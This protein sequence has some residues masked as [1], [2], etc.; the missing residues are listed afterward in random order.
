M[1]FDLKSIEGSVPPLTGISVYFIPDF[2]EFLYSFFIFYS[3]ILSGIS[4]ALH[5]VVERSDLDI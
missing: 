1:V 5:S 4:R 2:F 3:Y